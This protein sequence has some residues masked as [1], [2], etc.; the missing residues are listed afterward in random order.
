MIHRFIRSQARAA[1]ALAVAAVAAVAV[2]GCGSSGTSNASTTAAAASAS[3]SRAGSKTLRVAD[4]GWTTRP[5]FD[6]DAR[7]D[8][9][10]P[11]DWSNFDTGAELIQ[12]VESGSVDLG[13]TSDIGLIAAVANAKVPLKAITV[14]TMPANL[15]KLITTKGS[16]I[17]SVAGLKGKTVAVTNGGGGYDFLSRALNKAGLSLSDVKL[18]NLSPEAAAAAFAANRIDAWATWEPYASEDIVDHDAHV[19]TTGAGLYQEQFFLITTAKVLADPTKVREIKWFIKHYEAG[20]AKT[21][22]DPSGWE[23]VYA[24]VHDLP[25]KIATLAAPN[26]TLQFTKVTSAGDAAFMTNEQYLKKIRIIQNVV[27][28]S[29]VLDRALNSAF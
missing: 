29:T 8:K 9:T 22:S 10:Y 4:V 1:S 17:S 20:E 19:V 16:G 3:G 12:G 28:P 26:Q 13:S 5:I 21:Q 27:N 2:S 14:G 6:F 24:K 15:Y 18:E 7:G 11:I 23:K 25:Q